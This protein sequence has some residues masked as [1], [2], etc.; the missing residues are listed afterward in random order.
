[1]KIRNGFVSNSSSSSFIVAVDDINSVEKVTITIDVDITKYADYF[2]STKEDLDNFI[3]DKYGFGD[4]DT[5]E[6]I[7]VDYGDF[8]H[9]EYEKLLDAIKRGKTIIAGSFTNE[10]QQDE[11]H[12]ALNGIPKDAEGI[13]IIYNEPGF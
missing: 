11:Y 1:M 6:K 7:F 9:E 3:I 4:I 2:I 5:L 8:E 10:G 13:E 12:L